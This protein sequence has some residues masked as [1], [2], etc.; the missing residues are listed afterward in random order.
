MDLDP[1]CNWATNLGLVNYIVSEKVMKKAESCHVVIR[2]YV[3]GGLVGSVTK[4][5]CCRMINYDFLRR[6][7]CLLN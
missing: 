6:I 3:K 5:K 7:N 1:G 2:S 4:Q